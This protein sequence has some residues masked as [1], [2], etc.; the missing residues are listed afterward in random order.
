MS[1]VVDTSTSRRL[2]GE[3]IVGVRQGIQFA[4]EVPMLTPRSD[5]LPGDI[6]A[7]LD[8]LSPSNPVVGLPRWMSPSFLHALL[9]VGKMRRRRSEDRLR[10][11]T[12]RIV[13]T[14][15]RHSSCSDCGGDSI[16]NLSWF[17]FYHG[18]SGRP[19]TCV[20][21]LEQVLLSSSKLCILI[22]PSELTVAALHQL[23]RFI[24]L[25]I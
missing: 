4:F 21:R 1:D 24:R 6:L 3:T 19:L 22:L 17:Q 20:L 23:L 10:W 9:L 7:R 5:K 2:L 12:R 13:M 8:A 15:R 14:S 18:T 16:P 11:R 25:R